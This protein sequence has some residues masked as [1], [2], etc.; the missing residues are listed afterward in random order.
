MLLDIVRVPNSPKT[1]LGVDY[2][3][4]HLEESQVSRISAI[5]KFRFLGGMS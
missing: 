4:I 2:R 5:R 3:N 1:R